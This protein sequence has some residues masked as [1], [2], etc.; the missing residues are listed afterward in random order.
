MPDVSHDELVT[1]AVARRKPCD[2]KGD[3]Y[4]DSLNWMSVLQLLRDNPDARLLWVSENS[5]DFAGEDE[6]QL[7]EQL[8]EDLRTVHAEDRV[9]WVHRLP[10]AV[11]RIA[12]GHVDDGDGSTRRLQELLEQQALTAF[13]SSMLPQQVVGTALSPE[14]AAL[15]TGTGRANLLDLRQ[16]HSPNYKATA[17]LAVDSAVVEFS[18]EAQVLIEIWLPVDLAVADDWIVTERTESEQR[19]NLVKPLRF[20]GILEVDKFGRPIS[21]EVSSIRALSDDPGLA[22][23]V[24]RRRLKSALSSGI[25]LD[26][27]RKATEGLQFGQLDA[28]RKTTEGLQFGQLDAIRKATEGLQFGQLD[29]IR[30]AT[31]GLQFG[32]FD[33]FRKVMKGMQSGRGA[34]SE[35]ARGDQGFDDDVP[36]PNSGDEPTPSEDDVDRGG[37]E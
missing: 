15:P 20:G 24:A 10:D 11:A 16:L 13:V 22:A 27:F 36:L 34:R 28:I 21:G 25:E 2:A 31:E 37:V 17:P 5:T 6:G 1:R 14:R 3:G 12:S 23:W 4:R 7:H 29:A 33:A 35:P 26:A 30:K 9:V 32:Q 8:R 19:V 18:V